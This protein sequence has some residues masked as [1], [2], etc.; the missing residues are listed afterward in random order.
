MNKSSI[1][2]LQLCSQSLLATGSYT[3]NHFSFDNQVILL[4]ILTYFLILTRLILSYN[5]RHIVTQKTSVNP[6]KYKSEHFLLL[7]VIIYYATRSFFDAQATYTVLN[8]TFDGV[9]L[10]QIDLDGSDDEYIITNCTFTYANNDAVNGGG[11]QLYIEYRAKV[12]INNCSFTSCRSENEGGAIWADIST[13][14]KL[15]IDGMCRFSRCTNYEYDSNYHGGG[16]IAVFIDGE[17]SQL[18]FEDGI[19]YDTCYTRFKGGALFIQSSNAANVTLGQTLFLDCW[20]QSNGGAIYLRFYDDTSYFQIE[21]DITIKNCYGGDSGGGMCVNVWSDIEINLSHTILFDN[22]QS[23]RGGQLYIVT[24]YTGI[25]IRITGDIQFKQCH[26]SQ[27]AGGLY[28]DSVDGSLIEI[29][30][31]T[32][33]GCT[34][35][36]FAGGATSEC[37]FGSQ[38][39]IRGLTIQNCETSGYGGGILLYVDGQYSTTQVIDL[40]VTSC[41]SYGQGGG[42]F[43]EVREESLIIFEGF[44]HVTNC[45]SQEEGGGIYV[46]TQGI[47]AEVDIKADLIIDSCTSMMDGGGMYV[48]FDFGGNVILRNKCKIINCKSEGGNGGGIYIQIDFQYSHQ[49]IM[50]DA[51]I[52]ECEAKADPDKSYPTGYGGGMFLTGSGDYDPSTLRLD[53]KGMRIL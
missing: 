16:A 24:D 6:L 34:S 28:I 8:Q 26:S 50:N 1:S 14:G 47:L 12:Y 43:I 17:N 33:D 25:K 9:G 10:G 48:N 18:I 53:L 13:G 41:S 40:T 21:G 3:C 31:F 5:S 20:S 37:Y 36:Q 22:C 7:S 52:Q 39:I 46:Q 42:I 45:T 11:M 4:I 23:Q 2:E 27:I 32:I 38:N 44:C 29:S 49:F 19:T 15:T 35:E 51:L 30:N